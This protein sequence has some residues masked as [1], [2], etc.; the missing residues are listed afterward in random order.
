MNVTLPTFVETFVEQ[1]FEVDVLL[2]AGSRYFL[3]SNAQIIR[4]SEMIGDEIRVKFE[5]ASK[6]WLFRA[7]SALDGRVTILA[8]ESLNAQFKELNA[9]TLANYSSS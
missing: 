5:V 4:E 7:L 8:P 2:P 1:N 3:E 6:A 9:T